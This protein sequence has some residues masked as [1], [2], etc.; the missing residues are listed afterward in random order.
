ML[1]EALLP[2]EFQ[3]KRQESIGRCFLNLLEL[4]VI[5]PQPF[6]EIGIDAG[7]CDGTSC[8]IIEE[9]FGGEVTY[10]ESDKR[11]FQVVKSKGYRVI[12]TDIID[13]LSY[14][15]GLSFI[16]FFGAPKQLDLL[17]LVENASHSLKNGG[18]LIVTG[19]KNL[20]PKMDQALQFG[21]QKFIFDKTHSWDQVLYLFKK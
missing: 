17:Q 3:R 11:Y 10:V 9:M 14:R 12:F 13:H 20:D 18:Y 1:H 4:G 5:L 8:G 21:G 7:C 19:Y 6:T 15:S 2:S 16:T